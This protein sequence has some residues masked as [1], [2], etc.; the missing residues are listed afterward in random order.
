MKTIQSLHNLGI[1]QSI[2][3]EIDYNKRVSKLKQFGIEKYFV[4]PQ[5]NS[6]SKSISI[7]KFA[8]LFHT[9]FLI[10]IDNH[11]LELKEVSPELPQLTCINVTNYRRD[12]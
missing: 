12:I 9:K 8:K 10:E 4:L 1:I 11:I 3:S 5:L 6:N 7:K 2:A